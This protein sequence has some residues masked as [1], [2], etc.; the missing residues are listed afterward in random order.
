MQFVLGTVHVSICQ[1]RYQILVLI[2]DEQLMHFARQC[3]EIRKFLRD[4]LPTGAREDPAHSEDGRRD[5]V[6]C[7]GRQSADRHDGKHRPAA[8]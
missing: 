2:S 6:R 7:H 4:V 3:F 8:A 1:A 5:V